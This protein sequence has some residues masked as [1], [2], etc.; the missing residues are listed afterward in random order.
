MIRSCFA[1][2]VFEGLGA[3]GSTVR[4]YHGG[5]RGTNYRWISERIEGTA[6]AL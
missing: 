3:K 1:T 2:F 5:M 4:I 6:L